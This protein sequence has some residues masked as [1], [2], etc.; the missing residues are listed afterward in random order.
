MCGLSWD[1]SAFVEEENLELMVA[2][3]PQEGFLLFVR[4]SKSLIEWWVGHLRV[5]EVYIGR[6][7]SLASFLLLFWML[8]CYCR[9]A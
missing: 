6:Q 1:G 5:R 7:W 2:T 4:F 9:K 8:C 3:G